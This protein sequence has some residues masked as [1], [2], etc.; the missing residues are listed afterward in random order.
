MLL[1]K[2][3][4][5]REALNLSTTKAWSQDLNQKFYQGRRSL[6]RYIIRCSTSGV[7]REMQIKTVMK[8]HVKSTRLNW[9]L[10]GKLSQQTWGCSTI[11]MARHW[12]A[13]VQQALSKY[14]ANPRIERPEW[15]KQNG[16]S[17]AQYGLLPRFVCP[18]SVYKFELIAKS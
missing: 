2:K 1:K 8:F 15:R 10:I 3:N 16:S 4:S 6:Y 12:E 7:I 13:Q 18:W 9:Y 5:I 17:W 14:F 11:N